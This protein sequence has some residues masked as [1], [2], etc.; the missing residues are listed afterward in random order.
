MGKIE[1]MLKNPWVFL[2]LAI[3]FLTVPGVILSYMGI[4][5]PVGESSY[6]GEVVDIQHDK[7]YIF[8]TTQVY[9]KTDPTAS[10]VET[11]CVQTNK[12]PELYQSI[13]QNY[14]EGNKIQVD[15]S[16]PLFVSPF[17][18]QGGLSTVDSV[19]PVN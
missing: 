7:G 5:A 9:M 10:A 14:E 11:F 8:R 3:I 4:S 2:G 12:K 15:Y 1:F 19:S 16:R 17:Q 13:K 18:C 6:T